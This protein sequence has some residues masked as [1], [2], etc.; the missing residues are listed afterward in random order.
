MGGN[1]PALLRDYGQFVLESTRPIPRD[2]QAGGG[3]LPWWRCLTHPWRCLRRPRAAQVDVHERIASRVYRRL[4]QRHIQLQVAERE[5]SEYL[6]HHAWEQDYECARARRKT[7][8]GGGDAMYPWPAGK[9]EECRSPNRD[10]ISRHP[11]AIVYRLATTDLFVEKAIAYL[12]EH[13]A[14]YKINATFA[15]VSSIVVLLAATTF[16]GIREF[17]GDGLI[18]MTRQLINMGGRGPQ[19]YP[20]LS[21]EDLQIPWPLVLMDFS[22]GFTAYGMAVLVA[23]MLWRYGKAM[24]DQCERIMERRHALRQGRLFVHLNDGH[25]DIDEM[26]KAFNWNQSQSNAFAHLKDD[27]QAPWGAVAKELARSVPELVKAGIRATAKEEDKAKR[28]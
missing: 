17:E 3:R 6:A 9:G 14:S 23:V 11:D 27:A 12:E 15:H 25:L 26:E 5:A 4:R 28:A 19:G 7:R 21:P 18:E 20:V 13:A 16:A 24:L 22:R 8:S 2:D 1:R 10:H